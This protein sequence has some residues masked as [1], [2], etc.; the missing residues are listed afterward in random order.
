MHAA[1]RLNVTSILDTNKHKSTSATELCGLERNGELGK[2][3]SMIQKITGFKV[4]ISAALMNLAFLVRA[5]GDVQYGPSWEIPFALCTRL[6]NTAILSIA[7]E[8]FV[9]YCYFAAKRFKSQTI[10]AHRLFWLVL[11]LGI[12]LT[13]VSWTL[14]PEKWRFVNPALSAVARSGEYPIIVCCG[15]LWLVVLFRR[16]PSDAYRR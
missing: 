12:F 3:N 4:G 5:I 13:I 6:L 10:F 1:V 15:I 11:G 7:L 9:L 14:E 2:V 8:A 16:S